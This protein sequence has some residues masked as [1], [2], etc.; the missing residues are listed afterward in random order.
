LRTFTATVTDSL[1][2]A[3]IDWTFGDGTATSRTFRCTGTTSPFSCSNTHNYASA[4]TKTLSVIVTDK[5]GNQERVNAT[6]TV[7]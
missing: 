2:V 4:G 3:Y 1:G 6:I 5:H 7:S